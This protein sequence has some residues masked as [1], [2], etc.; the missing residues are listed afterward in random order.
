M[1][2]AGGSRAGKVLWA[3]RR[4]ESPQLRIRKPQKDMVSKWAPSVGSLH[5][6]MTGEERTGEGHC[7]EMKWCEQRRGGGG[8]TEEPA[9]E[10]Q[11]HL[12]GGEGS[13]KDWQGMSL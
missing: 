3:S 10:Q 2:D 6:E 5:K 7:R 9:S 13:E 4:V 11:I 8:P 1:K 12:A